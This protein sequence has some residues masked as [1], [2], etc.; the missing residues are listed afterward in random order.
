MIINVACALI[1]AMLVLALYDVNLHGPR[2][3]A[4]EKTHS[5]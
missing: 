5:H 1:F 3:A 2:W 4:E